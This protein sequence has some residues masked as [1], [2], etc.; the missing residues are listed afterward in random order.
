MKLWSS[1]WVSEDKNNECWNYWGK[2]ILRKDSKFNYLLAEW[3]LLKVLVRVSYIK[4]YE[5]LKML[6]SKLRPILT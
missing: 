1:I 4:K 2:L 5:N 3:D 6:E